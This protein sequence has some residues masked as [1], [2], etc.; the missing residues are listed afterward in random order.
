MN[1]QFI[2]PYSDESLFTLFCALI[3]WAVVRQRS[4]STQDNFFLIKGKPSVRL[5]YDRFQFVLYTS[6]EA[7]SLEWDYNPR[8]HAIQWSY[9]YNFVKFPQTFISEMYTYHFHIAQ[10][11][12]PGYHQLSST[13][14]EMLAHEVHFCSI[15]VNSY[16]IIA[17][18]C[19][20][21][22]YL[23]LLKYSFILW[24]QSLSMPTSSNTHWTALPIC[25]MFWLHV[26]VEIGRI[27]RDGALRG[28]RMGE[29]NSTQIKVNSLMPVQC[30]HWKCTL[31]TKFLQHFQ[32]YFT[33]HCNE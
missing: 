8:K 17:D 1:G 6:S 11:Y 5:E 18:Q 30:R 27:L 7:L 20:V 12:C 31:W 24:F 26:K 29:I 14:C 32:F 10:D 33:L 19:P 4:I 16:V 23:L 15:C 25:A 22:W 2:L 9:S 3:L 21:G 13:L 28:S